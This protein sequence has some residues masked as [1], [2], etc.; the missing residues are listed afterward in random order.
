MFQHTTPTQSDKTKADYVSRYHS[1]ARRFQKEKGWDEIDPNEVAATLIDRKGEFAQRTWRVYKAAVIHFIENHAGSSYYLAADTLRNESSKG[2][3]RWSD[4]TSGPKA[5]KVPLEILNGIRAALRARAKRGHRH[6]DGLM[7]VL[8]ATLIT[9]LRPNEWCTATVVPD[10]E[11]TL[12]RVRNSKF[13][14]G[15]GNGEFRELIL[16]ELD[17]EQMA[18]IRQ[19]IAYCSV[20]DADDPDDAIQR[21]VRSLKD[22]MITVMHMVDPIHQRKGGSSVTLYSFRH[23][24]IADAKNTF[25]DPVIVAALVG[26]SSTK[27]AFQHYGRRRH[28]RGIIKVLPTSESIEAVHKIH[29]ETYREFEATRL[30]GPSKG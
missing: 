23:Q 16:N 13:S 26:H 5:K 7:Q 8:E 30:H 29:L 18:S 20:N 15:R 21:L 28:G 19:A 11:R 4:R 17:A 25:D 9:G 12:L 27:T 10:G 24:F 14:N 1:L 22:E 6:A 3:K 2:L